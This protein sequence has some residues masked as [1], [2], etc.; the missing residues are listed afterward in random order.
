[1]KKQLRE[2]ARLQAARLERAMVDGRR[3]GVREFETLLVRRPLMFHLVRR[4]V[5]GG[6][7]DKLSL[8]K[9]FRVTED[10]EHV[11][12]KDAAVS[13]GDIASV[14]VVHPLHLGEGE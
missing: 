2:A 1:M 9:A 11:D 5:W 8:K 14:G 13:L 3:W 12:A 7:D 4:L 6:Y 10:K